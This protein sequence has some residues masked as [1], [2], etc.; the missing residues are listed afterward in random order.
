MTNILSG[1]HFIIL[2]HQKATL[3]KVELGALLTGRWMDGQT[4]GW[5]MLDCTFGT[6][7]LERGIRESTKANLIN[8]TFMSMRPFC[9]TGK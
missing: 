8:Q 4:E 2:G 3:K 6:V 7:H 9:M 5:T 1:N